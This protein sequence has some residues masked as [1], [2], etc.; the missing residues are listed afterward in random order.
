MK[1][2]K[3]KRIIFIDM[4]G[5]LADFGERV[6]QVE[7]ALGKRHV[8]KVDEISF[9]F[10]DLNPVDGAVEAVKKLHQS[11]IYD[12]YIASTS[13]WENPTA[14]QDK[15]DWIEKHFGG[16]FYKKVIFSH[17]KHLLCGDYLIDDR[18][19]NGA[20]RFKGKLLR[21]GVDHETGKLNEFPDWDAVLKYLL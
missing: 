20:D 16:I 4:D 10:R 7:A 13:P 9:V 18:L 15:K 6:R 11:E 17:N 19:M 2:C 21:F 8:D 14:L 12:L 1:H 5:V 3:E